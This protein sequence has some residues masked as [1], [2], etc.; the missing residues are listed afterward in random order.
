MVLDVASGETVEQVYRFS[1]LLPS[2]TKQGNGGS[3]TVRSF[4]N[5]DSSLPHAQNALDTDSFFPFSRRAT[6]CVILS[7]QTGAGWGTWTW[8]E[9]EYLQRWLSRPPHVLIHQPHR[10]T[11]LFCRPVGCGVAEGVVALQC[12]IPQDLGLRALL[13]GPTAPSPCNFNAFTT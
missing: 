11:E 9:P 2:C 8:V 7:T 3:P 6:S 13:A 12:R 1:R 10:L 4:L 5:R